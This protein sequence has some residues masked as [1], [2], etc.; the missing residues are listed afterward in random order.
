MMTEERRS[1]DQRINKMVDDIGQIKV[2][3]AQIQ[4]SIAGEQKLGDV[5]NAA[6]AKEL[7]EHRFQLEEQ[8]KKIRKVEDWNLITKVAAFTGSSGTLYTIIKALGF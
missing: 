7:A 3:V 8:S 5:L 1:D 2:A 6:I 4:T